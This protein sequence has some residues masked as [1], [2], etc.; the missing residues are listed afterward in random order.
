M[1]LLRKIGNNEETSQ[2]GSL[3]ST[4]K[5]RKVPWNLPTSLLIILNYSQLF[6]LCLMESL[7]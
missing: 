4:C 6:G 5:F 2:V 1:E 3:E 7:K